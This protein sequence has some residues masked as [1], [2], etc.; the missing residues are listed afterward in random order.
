YYLRRF[1]KFFESLLDESG[2]QR[3]A[4]SKELG[5][6]FG[7]IKEALKDHLHLLDSPINDSDRKDVTDALGNAGSTYRT[8][9]YEKG[10]AGDVSEIQAS[11]ISE[12]IVVALQFLEH[13]IRANQRTDKLYHAYNLM[14]IKGGEISVSH[15]SEMLE[16]QVAALSSGYLTVN[17]SLD[18]LDAMRNSALYRADQ[19]SF[20]LY[21]NKELPGF[22]EKNNIPESAIDKSELL[23]SLIESG[24]SRIVEKDLNGDYHFNGTFKNARDLKSALD[25]LGES[26]NIDREEEE[27]VLD[28]FESVFDHKSFTGRSGTFFGYEGL[29]SIYWHMVSKLH[30]AVLEICQ[31]AEREGADLA[32]RNRLAIH[33]DEIGKGIGVHK[34][35]ERYGAFPTDPY[36]HTPWHKGAQQ[37]GMTGQ[38]KEDV[39]VRFGELG[40]SV[41]DGKLHF[42]PFLLKKDAFSEGELQ[43]EF[44]GRNDQNQSLSIPKNSIGFSC[45]T[46]PVTYLQSKEDAIEATFN[47]GS[48]KKFEG[49][50]TDRETARMIFQRNGEV[51]H[52]TVHI[53][54]DRLR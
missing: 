22:L 54:S 23:K 10:F 16:G 32:L 19:N 31:R 13:A 45:C 14:H 34:E 27:R 8:K 36:S 33:F 3:M 37:P 5:A 35:P 20:M 11:E 15:L 24:D 47:D 4:I 25:A 38:V 42:Q 46:V 6:F 41:T 29:G 7:E 48:K 44:S 39:L 30:F 52:L 12:F 40:V 1:L 9:I 26:R 21:P 17:D 2:N 51:E 28:I 50:S 18:V 43:L 53:N 49:L